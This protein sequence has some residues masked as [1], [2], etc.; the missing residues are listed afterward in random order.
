MT[1][2]KAFI[3]MLLVVAI[4]MSGGIFLYKKAFH[5]E[6]LYF[7]ISD[8]KLMATVKDNSVIL[9]PDAYIDVYSEKNEL[10]KSDAVPHESFVTQDSIEDLDFFIEEDS[11]LWK[12]VKAKICNTEMNASTGSTKTNC[13]D[14]TEWIAKFNRSRQSTL[15]NHEMMQFTI[16]GA[17]ARRAA[18][19]LRVGGRQF[20]DTVEVK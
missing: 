2:R 3:M 16:K 18:M 6:Q 20:S 8:V 7:K 1:Q 19:I 13:V 15:L 10:L 11:M 9:S 17:S 5:K 4:G 12:P 14:Q